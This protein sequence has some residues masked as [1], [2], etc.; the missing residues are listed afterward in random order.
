MK[1]REEKEEWKRRNKR[2]DE[3]GDAMERKK[4]STNKKRMEEISESIKTVA[5]ETK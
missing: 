5:I 2:K 3:K 4:G 1:K